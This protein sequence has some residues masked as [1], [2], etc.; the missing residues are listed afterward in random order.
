MKRTLL[1]L[2][3]SLTLL[4]GCSSHGII[5]TCHDTS[6]CRYVGNGLYLCWAI[7]PPPP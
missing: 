4:A 2:L 3:L 6:C 5:T 7:Y 1:A